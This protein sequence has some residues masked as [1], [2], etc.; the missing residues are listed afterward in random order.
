MPAQHQLCT[1]RR[2]FGGR[3]AECVG[4]TLV[5]DSDMRAAL[6]QKAHGG[7]PT[8]SETDYQRVLPRELHHHLNFN[9]A[10]LNTASMMAM[11][12]KRTMTRGSGQPFF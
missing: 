5:V 10:R 1:K 11:I 2:G 12:Q 9:V 3:D 7:E 4:V 6:R 8:L